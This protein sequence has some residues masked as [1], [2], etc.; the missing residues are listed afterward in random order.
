MVPHISISI[1]LP[2]VTV[3]YYKQYRTVGEFVFSLIDRADNNTICC[4]YLYACV[5]S[6]PLCSV[7]CVH[8]YT[9]RDVYIYTLTP[10]I[11]APVP[12]LFLDHIRIHEFIRT[13]C[14]RLS[15][16]N[17]GAINCGESGAGAAVIL[18]C[19]VLSLFIYFSLLVNYFLINVVW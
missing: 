16:L 18:C 7:Q 9:R 4:T 8:P 3:L 13:V 5:A 19:P 6:A 12:L 14:T 1:Y 11:T 17:C 2:V 10:L 15:I